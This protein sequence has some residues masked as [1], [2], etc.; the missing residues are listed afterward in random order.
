MPYFTHH[1]EHA[2]WSTMFRRKPHK[3]LSTKLRKVR[4]L[5]PHGRVMLTFAAGGRAAAAPGSVADG[6]KVID[7]AVKAFGTVHVL[8]NNAGIIRKSPNAQRIWY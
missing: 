6:Q 1:E 2:W 4:V 5:L 7:A 8:I 3:R